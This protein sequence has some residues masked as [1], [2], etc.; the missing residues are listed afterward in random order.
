[1][2]REVPP[3]SRREPN[4]K[5][6]PQERKRRTGSRSLLAAGLAAAVIG[7]FF[8]GAR[9]SEFLCDVLGI[10]SATVRLGMKVASIVVAIPAG[11]YLVERYFLSRSTRTPGK[12]AGTPDP[13]SKP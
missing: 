5:P 12:S 4:L 9:I 8:V 2:K 6:P 13:E 7:A 10:T 3:R 11:F 1:M